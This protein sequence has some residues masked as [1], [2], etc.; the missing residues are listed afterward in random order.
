[1]HKYLETH[2]QITGVLLV[3]FKEQ[4]NIDLEN[5]MAVRK[6]LY[7]LELA[8][9]LAHEDLYAGE[10]ES[11]DEG[12]GF[13]APD[14]EV[15]V[16][17][18]NNVNL[19]VAEGIIA[20]LQM[21]VEKATSGKQ[22]L[23]M[24]EKKHY[25]LIFMDHMMPE[26]DGVETTRLIRRFHEDYNDVPIIALTA[27]VM[28]EMQGMF[29]VE[30]MND[31]VAKPIET[32]VIVAKI[33]QWLS[34]EKMQRVESK[35]KSREYELGRKGPEKIDI[36]QLNIEHALQLV[37]NEDLFWQVLREYARVIPKKAGMLEQYF[38]AG[39]WKTYTIET[40]A[41]KSSSK[42]I[43]A[44]ALS[45]LAAQME[46]AGNNNNIEFI[47]MHHSEL[48]EQYRGYEPIL[49]RYFEVP[50]E[51][52]KPKAIYD[53]EIILGYLDNMQEAVDNLDMDKMDKVIGLL[54]QVALEERETQCFVKMREAVEEL[55]AESCEE[56]IKEWRQ[57][58]HM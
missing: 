20:P 38:D 22:A 50:E 29:L 35:E 42:Q 53:A 14:A 5:V 54:E 44:M 41:L 6:P 25:D 16:V 39:D 8:K 30:G 52:V 13:I 2:P 27:N 45:E 46:Q 9:I 36:P 17:D 32:K 26:L 49:A 18:D 11:E 34:P 31:F 37:G 1:M 7:I 23:E 24:I 3:G 19:I 40:H 55:D 4:I 21:K 56:L 15:L 28:E 57:L 58:I 12:L 33:K 47:R 43:G 51:E 10:E 48:L